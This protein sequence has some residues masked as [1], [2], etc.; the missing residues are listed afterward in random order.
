MKGRTPL[1]KHGLVVLVCWVLL[2]ALLF[3]ATA[4]FAVMAD[5]KTASPRTVLD[6]QAGTAVLEFNGYAEARTAVTLPET[7]PGMVVV[8]SPSDEWAI[9]AYVGC[10]PLGEGM[11]GI[12]A[13]MPY[14]ST[15]TLTVHWIAV[16]ATGAGAAGGTAVEGK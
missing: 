11:I 4:V 3:L 13:Q 7:I 8:C 2:S 16:G 9:G 1:L 6:G 10:Q 14:T 12:T 5:S 15:G